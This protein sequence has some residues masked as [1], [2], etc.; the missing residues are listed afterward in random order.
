MFVIGEVREARRGNPVDCFVATLL[1]MTGFQEAGE[2]GRPC[3]LRTAH[4][5]A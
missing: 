2:L 1:G 5:W 4:L 3:A